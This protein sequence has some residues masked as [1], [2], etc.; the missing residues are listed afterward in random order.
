MRD[1]A[2]HF[3]AAAGR[4]DIAV[5]GRDLLADPTPATTMILALGCD[6]RARP[7]D[8][9]PG[10]PAPAGLGDRR[11]WCGDAL[12]RAGRRVG[13]RLWLLA[14]AK[15]TEATRLRAERYAGEALA[16]L[17]R[18]LGLDIAI[19]AEWARRGVLR[20]T[21]RAGRARVVVLQAVA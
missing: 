10:A 9:L 13:S 6:R 18:D 4:F 21:C 20:L 15:Q 8:V 12:D 3:D 16:R 1:I 14:R 5:S 17:P 7:D 11:G 19:A 2:L